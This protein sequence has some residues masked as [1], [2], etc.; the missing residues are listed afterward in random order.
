MAI[1]IQAGTDWAYAWPVLD[2]D[3]LPVDLTGWSAH[4]VLRANKYFPELPILFEWT[5]EGDTPNASLANS[6]VTL[7]VNP[8]ESDSW[9]WWSGTLQIKLV[10]VSGKTARFIEQDVVVTPDVVV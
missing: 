6:A 10:N 9:D 3:G 8:D 7:S 4:A 2:S 1:E 5:S